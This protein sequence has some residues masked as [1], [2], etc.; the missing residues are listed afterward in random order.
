MCIILYERGDSYLTL[1]VPLPLKSH[2]GCIFWA[3]NSSL[4]FCD[5]A[6]YVQW[7]G[8]AGMGRE[9]MYNRMKGWE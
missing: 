2:A 8:N 4:P 6:P 9:T 5:S 7:N 3:F 1:Q